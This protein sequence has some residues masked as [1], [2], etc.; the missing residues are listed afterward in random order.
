MNNFLESGDY[1]PKPLRDF[2]DAKNVFKTIH[3]FTNLEKFPP[4]IKE[5]G[6]VN[7]HIY[8]VDVFLWFMAK[9]GYTLQKSRRK[10][11]FRSLEEDIEARKQQEEQ[12]FKTMLNARK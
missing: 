11:N 7:A 5:L 2:H 8:V 10:E 4:Q 12:I 3:H 6:W 9:R 1:L